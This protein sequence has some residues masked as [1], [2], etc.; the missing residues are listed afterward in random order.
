MTRAEVKRNI[1]LYYIIQAVFGTFFQQAIWIAYQSSFLDFEQIAYYATVAVVVNLIMQIPTGALADVFGRKATLSIA[2]LLLALPMFLIAFFPQPEVMLLYAILWG[3][4]SALQDGPD[5]SILYDSLKQIGE[6][7][8]FAKINSRGTLSFQI[9]MAVSV[10]IGAYIYQVSPSLTYIVSGLASLIGV[11]VSLLFVD[12]F[13]RE[14][15]TQITKFIETNWRG[16]KEAFKSS[17]IAKIS[18]FYVL[19]YGISSPTQKFLIQPYMQEIGMDDIT[20]GWV[21]MIVKILISLIGVWL[22]SKKKLFDNKWFIFTIPVIMIL[23]L[24]PAEFAQSPFT[25]LIIFGVAFSSGNAGMFLLPTVHKFIDSKVRTTAISSLKMLSALVY[26]IVTYLSGKVTEEA[27]VGRFFLY[28]GI[29]T[30]IVLIPL[31]IL[32]FKDKP[33]NNE[34]K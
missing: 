29:F 30:I 14:E 28:E 10:V 11:V 25:Y 32:I 21:A 31:A 23:T 1:T 22:V 4:G 19:L 2:N 26:S 24:I 9:T 17:S 34:Y 6:E 5:K 20:R 33:N 18:I 3:T 12:D 27:S 8:Q 7:D 15:N 16:F 13:K